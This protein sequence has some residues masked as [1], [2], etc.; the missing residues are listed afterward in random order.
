MAKLVVV[1]VVVVIARSWK[2][3]WPWF[4]QAIMLLSVNTYYVRLSHCWRRWRATKPIPSCF[5]ISPAAHS[6]C[7]DRLLWHPGTVLDSTLVNQA[8]Q[9]RRSAWQGW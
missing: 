6:L 1:V 5:C 2:W 3:P 9:V 7:S 8:N 4:S